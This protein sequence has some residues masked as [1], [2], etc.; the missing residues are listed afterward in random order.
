MLKDLKDLLNQ[1]IE[2]LVIHQNVLDGAVSQFRGDLSHANV[3]QLGFKLKV[4][5][6]LD[7]R[8]VHLRKLSVHLGF[9]R[10]V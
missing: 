4:V 9:I 8:A 10:S 7:V 2:I 5:V 3:K 6:E 1:R